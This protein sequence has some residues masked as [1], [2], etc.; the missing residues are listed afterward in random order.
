MEAPDG[1]RIVP[2]PKELAAF[3]DPNWTISL[4]DRE[5]NIQHIEFPRLNVALD[6]KDIGPAAA[7]G[8]A[9]AWKGHEGW[10]LARRQY[11]PDLV[12]VGALVF[13]KQPKASDTDQTT[14]KLVVCPV[15]DPKEMAE[16]VFPPLYQYDYAHDAVGTAT[17]PNGLVSAD[18]VEFEL[19]D[20][21]LI[22]KSLRA[23]YYL[24]RIL[25]EQGDFDKAE[26]LFFSHGAFAT[27]ER[28]SEGERDILKKIA[29][30]NVSKSIDPRKTR[31][32]VQALLILQK[33]NA[34]FPPPSLDLKANKTL[35]EQLRAQLEFHAAALS[36]GGQ[37]DLLY[38]YEQHK[39]GIKPFDPLDIQFL[40]SQIK[41]IPEQFAGGFAMDKLW[42]LRGGAVGPPQITVGFFP[43]FHTIF[44]KSDLSLSRQAQV[45]FAYT[46]AL[47][48][49]SVPF[50]VS[51]VS[52]DELFQYHRLMKKDFREGNVDKLDTDGTSPCRRVPLLLPKGQPPNS[53]FGEI[54]IRSNSWNL[55]FSGRKCAARASATDHPRNGKRS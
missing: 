4:A 30:N 51:N 9:F 42:Q 13:E 34:Q 22:P 7:A 37:I 41:H 23:R 31:L 6:R 29:L 20:G 8:A 27:K 16:D 15:W 25:A 43:L 38:T 48:R 10:L 45:F 21:E 55:S 33:N 19:K 54:F 40:I 49:R 46:R 36:E 5:G 14:K 35:E 24:A 18:T 28:L 2:A 11:V 39:H 50:D 47:L 53:R 3:E 32:R 52:F 17:E 44:P 12:G 26:K 1:S